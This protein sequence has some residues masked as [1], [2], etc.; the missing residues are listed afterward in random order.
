[1]ND[2]TDAELVRKEY[3]SEAALA[4]R[5]GAYRWA[6]G[7]DSIALC[8]AAVAEVSPTRV[9]DAG[10]GRGDIAERIANEI[11]AS[12]IGLDQSERMIELT[13]ARGI[14]AIV[15]DVCRLPFERGAFECA[16][17][18]WM[19]F[20]VADVDA[21]LTELARVLEPDGRLVAAT[22]SESSMAGLRELVGAPTPSYTFS[23]ENGEEILR[24]HFRRVERHDAVGTIRFPDRAAVQEYVDS[25]ITFS[26][27]VPNTIPEPFVVSRASCVFVADK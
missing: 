21:A 16:L 9:L 25:A 22:N 23:V 14:E 7:P 26:G 10:C 15:G 5:S 2:L 11:G 20:H 18:A 1:M 8:I 4:V 17:A 27:K 3:A 19:L 12:V 13:R 6:D 24:R